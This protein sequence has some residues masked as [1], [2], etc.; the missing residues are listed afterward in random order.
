[1]ELIQVK[2]TFLKQSTMRKIKL[3]LFGMLVLLSAG[4]F[5]SCIDDI[6]TS[7][8]KIDDSQKA[9]VKVWV[10]AD[11]DRNNSA[12]DFVPNGTKVLVSVDNSEL[13]S[14]ASSGSWSEVATVNGGYIEIQVP[15]R[16][17]GVTVTLKAEDFR[18]DQVQQQ[19]AGMERI[20][21]LYKHTGTTLYSVRTGQTVIS[22]II[23][24]N[25]PS[26][27]FVETATIRVYLYAELDKT[28]LGMEFAPDGTNVLVSIPGSWSKTVQ[29]KDGFVELEVPTTSSGVDV[30]IH[31]AEFIYY[32]VQS[33]AS[34]SEPIRK[35]FKFNG[36]NGSIYSL[37]SNESR[38]HEIEY[39]ATNYGRIP[40]T[41]TIKFVAYAD[42]DATEW[43]STLVPWGTQI[44]L[45]NEGWAHTVTVGQNG[46]F[47]AD[48]PKN[49]TIYARFTAMKKVQSNPLLRHNYIYNSGQMYFG[50]PNTTAYELHFGGG[51]QL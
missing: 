47:E 22:E 40:E 15:A 27:N 45:F 38:I 5:T 1:M 43:G 12:L 19:G 37:K 10:F 9:T 26:S 30:N 3:E 6:V 41:V 35:L 7:E 17:D 44:T 31:P 46:R 28:K 36:I 16:S 49:Q 50:Q 14:A 25:N 34:N 18:Y 2:L 24:Q 32:Q 51:Q 33:F 4:F 8:L 21:T 13:N 39:M 11:L 29:V 48:V 20:P 42:L 23:Y